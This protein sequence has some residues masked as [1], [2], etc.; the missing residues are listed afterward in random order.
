VITAD[1]HKRR[2]PLLLNPA[3]MMRIV[4]VVLFATVTAIPVEML[5]FHDVIQGRLN[6]EVQ[7]TR[8]QARQLLRGDF[9]KDL[10]DLAKEEGE[11]RKR[12][13][14]EAPKV[15][16]EDL[17]TPELDKKLKE[18]TAS[19][20]QT[21]TDLREEAK[22]WR[23][24]IPGEGRRWLRLKDQKEALERQIAD[25]KTSRAAEIDRR[26]ATNRKAHT[27]ATET[28]FQELSRI[29][30][31][32]ETRRRE[33]EAKLRGVDRMSDEE[34]KTATKREF[35]V[36]DGFARR[37]KLMNDLENEDPIFGM[38]K[39]AVRVLFVAFGLLV[40]TT[41]ALFN[42]PTRA[43]YAGLDPLRPPQE[44]I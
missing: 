14:D 11:A 26:S 13:K 6:G 7:G 41:K 32:Y 24:G 8:E 43:Y 23:S 20:D 18:L 29:S 30:E 9:K 3:I 35:K 37:W 4:V 39:W 38:T 33:I 34:L 19:L 17:A 31:R 25:T 12:V 21:V 40:L 1:V 22:G 27:A 10:E 28:H 15:D 44:W 5:V 2:V 36:A 16:V 42:R